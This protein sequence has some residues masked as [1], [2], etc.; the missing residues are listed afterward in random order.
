M[1]RRAVRV[2][3]LVAALFVINVIARLVARLA[4]GDGT[5]DH[6]AAQ[7]RLAWIGWLAIAFAMAAAAWWWGRLRPQGAVV[8]DLATAA[9]AAGL[10]YVL[11]GPFVSEP[12]RFDGGLGGGIIALTIYLGVTG[13]GALVGMLLL[14]ALGRDQR[15][16]AL[17]RYA[18]A[19]STRPRRAVRR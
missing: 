2:G 9:A 19:R 8:A 6:L 7:D 15:S 3:I 14:V 1:T 5:P 13:V 18:Q 11:V 4:Y 10:L 16:Q 17:R 12:P